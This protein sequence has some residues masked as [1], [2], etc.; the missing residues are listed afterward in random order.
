[1]YYLILVGA[2][3]IFLGGMFLIHRLFPSKEKLIIERIFVF[4]LIAVFAVRF[5][6]YNDVQ[7]MSSNYSNYA[8][9]GGPMT[10]WRCSNCHEEITS[11]LEPA[12]VC[13]E[14]YW[15]NGVAPEAHMIKDGFLN[16]AGNICIW[17]E[18]TAALMVLLRPWARFKTAKF[19]VKCIALPILFVSAIALYP[20][21]HMMQGHDDWSLLTVMLPIEIGGLLSLSLYYLAKDYKV[22]IS[23]HSYAEVA[24][25]SV[26][27]NI[28]TMQPYMLSFL[29]GMGGDGRTVV[30]FTIY[31]RVYLYLACIIIPLAIYF[32]F[33][34]AHQDKIRYALIFISL[35]TFLSFMVDYKYDTILTPW[36]WP[37]HLCNL[38]MLLVPICLIFKLK[39]L[40]HFT[41]FINVFGAVLAMLMPN[42][43]ETLL[44]LN[45]TVVHFWIN[46]CCAFM[47]PLLCVALGE[48]GRPSLKNFAYSSIWF[49]VYF[50]IVI[51]LNTI[52]TALEGKVT[53]VGTIS[54]TD[55]F[56]IN[57]TFIAK[58]LGK[59]AES[60][61]DM[62]LTIT[63]SEAAFTFHPIYQ[64]I[65]YFVY[66]LLGFGIWFV[67]QI[68]FDIADSHIALHY[69]LK[70]IR[71]DA[72]ALKSALN[73][74]S[75]DKPMDENSGISLVLDNFC[76]RYGLN[77]HYSA[78]NVCLS[79]KG[80]EVFGF[81]GPNG[82][83]KSTCIKSIVGIQPITDG[84]I[85]VCGY[86]VKTQPVGAKSLIGFVPDHYALYENLTGREYL[87]YIADIYDVS[88]EDRNERISRY[89]ERFELKDS[90]DNK[91]KT[92]SHGMKQKVTII[93]ALV[94]DPKVWI[95][96]EPLTG[97]DPTSIY[98]V[99]ECMREH[100]AKGNIVFFSSHLIDIVEKLCD[101]IAI[102]KHGEIQATTTVKEIEA[103]G[104]TLE[105]FYLK[106]I[107]DTV[108]KAGN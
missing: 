55:Y 97:L 76:K 13:A 75:L 37:L 60:I 83:G 31:H 39:K 8:S 16:F 9:L 50:T 92:Y 93:S 44:Y 27:I 26:F 41:Y 46:H 57:S 56:F 58:K 32:S 17:L 30:D 7:F 100:A 35:G 80:G 45:P 106:I 96:D 88:K 94:H 73:G 48:F 10:I 99:K 3:A 91:I 49:F 85:S 19:Y 78:K 42:Y 86:D 12:H 34:N 51:T 87:N 4:V 38:A 71:I 18:I 36:N 65:Y 2:I 21:L 102:I 53:A 11:L 22:R 40:F 5:M 82:A 23:K 108:T 47:M 64:L 107:G 98:Q 77:K 61:F 28:A 29:F 25:F 54:G 68:F 105:E 72:I 69:K 1:M 62:R 6:S 81:L 66:A 63:T 67:Y 95:L 24:T 43:T 52:F 84:H 74:R 90:I 103:G 101:R 104:Q 33:R 20:M 79:V 89:V 70:G 14:K 15:I 59:W